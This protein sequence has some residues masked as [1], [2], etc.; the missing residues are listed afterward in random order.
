MRNLKKLARRKARQSMHNNED[1][2]VINTVSPEPVKLGRLAEIKAKARAA[3]KH[4]RRIPY[5][6]WLWEKACEAVDYFSTVILPYV[7]NI[8]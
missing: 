2:R 4:I 6:C 7:E 8:L 5:Y 3:A 1:A